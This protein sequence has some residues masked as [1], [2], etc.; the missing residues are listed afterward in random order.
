MLCYASKLRPRLKSNVHWIVLEGAGAS[1]ASVPVPKASAARPASSTPVLNTVPVT[2]TVCQEPA[3]ASKAGQGAIVL[4]TPAVIA[5]LTA[6]VSLASASASW[7]GLAIAA[8][9]PPVP[10][11]APGTALA[12]RVSATAQTAGPALAAVRTR[13]PATAPVMAHAR[14]VN[15]NVWT[16]GRPSKI[17]L[18]TLVRCPALTLLVTGNVMWAPRSASAAPAGLAPAANRACAGTTVPE[19]ASVSAAG[20]SASMGSMATIVASKIRAREKF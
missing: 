1:A 19:T 20:A 14:P 9:S 8:R 5:R 6:A 18:P 11:P 17:V 4:S 15:A 16:V 3:N 7:A 12:S 13:A 10:R 2:E